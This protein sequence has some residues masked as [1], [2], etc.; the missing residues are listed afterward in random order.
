[1][2]RRADG[3]PHRERRAAPRDTDE[4]LLRRALVMKE[5]TLGP[6]NPSVANT[7]T[8]LAEVLDHLG[9]RDEAAQMRLRAAAITR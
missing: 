4:A 6:Y 7:L 8:N 2:I 3:D 1:M 5:N 9:R